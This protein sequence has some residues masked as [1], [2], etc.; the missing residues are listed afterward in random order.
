MNVMKTLWASIQGDPKFMSKLHGW[1]T[2]IWAFVT[3]PMLV[4][5]WYQSIAFI[6]VLSLYAIVTGHWSSWQ[7]SRVEVR[8]E[9]IHEEDKAS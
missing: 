8:Q 5:G 6:S 4:L 9:E 1:L 7:A 2:I 3:I